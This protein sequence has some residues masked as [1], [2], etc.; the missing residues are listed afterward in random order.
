[1]SN[2][3][4]IVGA[5][6]CLLIIGSGYWFYLVSSFESDL[7]SSNTFVVEDDNSP[8]SNGTNDSLLTIGFDSGSDDLEWAFTTITLDD[9]SN[10]YDCTLGGISSTLQK[11]GNIQSNLNADGQTFTI[12]VDATSETSFTKLFLPEM[13]E[14]ESTNFT[15]RFSK[16]DIYLGE[17]VSWTSVD[18]V[19]FNQL[20]EIP[21]DNFSDD[22]SERL[23]WYDYDL[24]T[25]RVEPKDRIYI[26]NLY[27]TTY[28]IQFLS[29]YNQADESRHV[30]MIVSW[31]DGDPIPAFSNP[32]L[33]QSSPCIIIDEDLI[34][35]SD[36]IIL[37]NENGI[38][39]C[40][41]NCLLN[42][43]VTF[44][45]VGLKGTASIDLE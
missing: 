11:E 25:H 45:N 30:T 2:W 38:D 26:L 9:G 17:N 3:K 33:V 41:S 44:E 15:L 19:E 16:T 32:D 34:W 40:K 10:E 18:N 37:I 42:I 5:V 14:T 35:S 13:S 1:M 4:K 39:I 43:T 28:K 7:G 8:L 12:L 21:T 31:L 29:Y 23:D 27:Q 22:T 24:S 36:E 20:T 6:V